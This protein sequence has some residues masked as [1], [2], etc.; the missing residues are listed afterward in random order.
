MGDMTWGYI[1]SLSL[2][3]PLEIQLV[4]WCLCSLQV[5]PSIPPYK[6]ISRTDFID[7]LCSLST[8]YAGFPFE[9]SN[10][11]TA[12]IVSVTEFGPDPLLVKSESD[13]GPEDLAVASK[14]TSAE[15]SSSSKL[16]TDKLEKS[17][18][19]QSCLAKNVNSYGKMRIIRGSQQISLIW[20][21]CAWENRFY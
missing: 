2:S 8:V 17:K 19:Q 12:P 11:K 16:P 4:P 6:T 21:E 9:Q 15:L 10:E 7:K 1:S 14:T 3:A 13:L 18:Q 5:V 20:W